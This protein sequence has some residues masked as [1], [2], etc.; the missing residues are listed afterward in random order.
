MSIEVEGMQIDQTADLPQ[1]EKADV[2]PLPSKKLIC[3]EYPGNVKNV[4]KAVETLGGINSIQRV[5]LISS[6]RILIIDYCRKHTHY[7]TSNLHK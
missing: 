5:R 3:V 2:K 4:D 1:Y 7:N 6:L